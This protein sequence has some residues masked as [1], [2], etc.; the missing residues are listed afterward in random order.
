MFGLEFTK[1]QKLALCAIAGLAVIGISV[2]LAKVSGIGASHEVVLQEPG[3]GS[4]AGVTVSDSDSTYNSGNVTFQVAGEVNAPNVYTLPR[5]S[6]IID[7][8]KAAGGAK[9]DADLQSMN[10]AAKIDD[11]SRIFVPVAQ[12]AA[13][14]ASSTGYAPAPPQ[15][16][17]PA[18]AS[19]AS[20]P[21]TYTPSASSKSAS[22]G[23]LRNPG[24]GVVHINSADAS[25]LQRLPG[26]GPSTAE[27]IIDYRR[28][29]G[30]FASLDQLM[31][32]KG[33][34]PKKLEK[35]KPFIAL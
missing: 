3:H 31:D 10:L 24:E 19:S 9:P 21:V 1:N 27:K 25:E 33:I 22:G 16:Q 12:G 35:M 11:G 29:I 8:V 30:R 6:R 32:V 13:P 18:T 23:K 26:V 15:A 28:Q 5:G 20:V 4:G 34:G 17:P 2:K 14:A 7:A